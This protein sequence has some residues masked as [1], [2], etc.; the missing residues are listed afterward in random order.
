M[1]NLQLIEHF[2]HS[3][4]ASKSVAVVDGNQS[5]TLRPFFMIVGTRYDKIRFSPFSESLRKKNAQ[6][7]SLLSK[8]RDCLIF[9]N[10]SSEEVIFPVDNLCWL[11]RE[12]ISSSI[13]ERIMSFQKD[14]GVSLP[15]P[16]CWYMFELRVKEE[17]SENE[18]GMISLESCC[19]I[20]INFRMNQDDVMKSI[21]YLHSMALFLY[22]P[23]VLPNVIFTNPQYL[24]DMLSKLIRV[25]FV[26]LLDDI[27]SEGQSLLSHIQ[28]EFRTNGVFEESFLDKL[29]LPFVSSLFTKTHFL[30][31][32][33]YLCIAAPFIGR[34]SKKCY[35]IPVVLPPRQ[36][37]DND[38]S[39]FM[40]SC[41]PMILTFQSN[42]V[43]QVS[44]F[45]H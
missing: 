1:T 17:A 14:V 11:N 27:L 45:F 12:K 26:D 4:A 36:L 28:H 10:E 35:F 21:T 9:Y 33:Q 5:L 16:V 39:V 38:K 18:H 43:P 23:V 25:S 24:L 15:I 42:V 32:L 31:L 40:K 6:I 3:V 41:D 34:D 19:T 7:L 20:G 44:F 30:D 37:T 22:F 13:R 2:V 8:F 29:C